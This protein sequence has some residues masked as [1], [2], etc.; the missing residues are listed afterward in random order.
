VIKVLASLGKKLTIAPMED[1]IVST[2]RSE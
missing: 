1:K 2:E